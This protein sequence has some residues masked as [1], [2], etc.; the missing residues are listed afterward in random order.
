MQRVTPE[1]MIDHVRQ[2]YQAVT[3]ADL[4]VQAASSSSSPEVPAEIVAAR[5]AELDALARMLPQVGAR[6]PPFSFVPPIDIIDRKS[7]LVVEVALPGVSK[8]N[9]DVKVVG[10][11]LVISGVR[12]WQSGSNGHG[13]STRFGEIPRGPFRRVVWIPAHLANEPIHTEHHD[14]ILVV[15]FGKKVA[16]AAKAKA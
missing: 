6:L 11:A 8:E 10:D 3:G 13:P 1:L 12:E 5:F 7:E 15:T 9:V 4:P 14:G 2:I 16:G